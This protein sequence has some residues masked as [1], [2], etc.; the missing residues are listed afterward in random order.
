VLRYDIYRDD[1]D[2]QDYL[3][4]LSEVVKRYNYHGIYYATVNRAVCQVG[5]E[6]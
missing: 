5:Q 3:S 4:I 6:M 1:H 2:R